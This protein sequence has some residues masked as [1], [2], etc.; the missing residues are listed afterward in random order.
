MK[1]KVHCANNLLNSLVEKAVR[2]VLL[3]LLLKPPV[4]CDIANVSFVGATSTSGKHPEDTT[5]PV[6]NKRARIARGR[7][8]TI[9]VAVGVLGEDTNF[10]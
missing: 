10:H 8:R 2:E 7:E 4:W 5:I 3:D 1:K 9:L 6:E